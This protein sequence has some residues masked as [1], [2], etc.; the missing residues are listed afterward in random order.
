[1]R[2]FLGKH[3]HYRYEIAMNLC[4]DLYAGTQDQNWLTRAFET[5]ERSKA[6]SLAQAI[7]VDQSDLKSLVPDSLLRRERDLKVL[8]S[9]YGKRLAQLPPK[10]P[11]RGRLDSIRLR[12]EESYVALQKQLERDY[13]AFYRG[14][15]AAGRPSLE[16]LQARLPE[17]AGLLEFFAGDSA[18]FRLAIT[19]DAVR[20]D[21][22]AKTPE[23]DSSMLAFRKAIAQPPDPNQSAADTWQ[24]FAQPGHALYQTLVA[25]AFGD[26]TLSHLTVVP[27]GALAELP[28]GLL[29]RS[30]PDAP[31]TSFPDINYLFRSTPISYAYAARLQNPE[32]KST[33]NA[34][35]KLLAMAPSTEGATQTQR[36]QTPGAL[37]H[38][39]AEVEAVSRIFGGEV[40]HGAAATKAHFL[41]HSSQ[42][43]FLHL[44]SHLLLND[45]M[46]MASRLLFAPDQDSTTSDDLHLYELYGLQLQANMAVLS[47]CNTGSGQFQRGEGQLSLA[48]GFRMAGCPAL[49]VSLWNA[50]DRTTAEL[51]SGFYAALKD[52]KGKSEALN[53]AREDYLKSADPYRSHPYFWG[54][55]MVIGDTSP[56]VTEEAAAGIWWYWVGG[57]TLALIL[58]LGLGRIF[59]RQTA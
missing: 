37:V 42:Y 22:I 6:F 9:S 13:P 48:W 49:V 32:A 25:T 38:T 20:L 29:V 54:S 34:P 55:F 18:Y 12:L 33:A 30:L 47:A 10:A 11:M 58:I 15:V 16:A 28:F 52:G 2:K 53:S 7:R 44:A 21:R 36:E 57:G 39:R 19:H 5:A 14:R 43:R 40:L 46:P 50:N 56:V 59:R 51:M 45:S 41:E 23:L 8:R 24:A 3:T 1:S 26:A 4:R 31:S 35:K 27:D 17:G